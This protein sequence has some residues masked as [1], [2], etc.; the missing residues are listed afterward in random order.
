SPE[1]S[2]AAAPVAG[3]IAPIAGGSPEA[4]KLPYPETVAVASLFAAATIFFG[5]IPGPLFHLAS[6]AGAALTGLF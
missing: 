5:V 2:R 4:D 3:A 1:G 6:H